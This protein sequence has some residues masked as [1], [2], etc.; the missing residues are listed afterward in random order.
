M[1][2]KDIELILMRQLANYLAVPILVVDPAGTL[3]FYNEPAEVLLGRGIEETGA[4][5]FAEWTRLFPMTAED[6]APLPPEARPLGTALQQQRATHG[7]F[8]IQGFNGIARSVEVTA[9]PLAGQGGR[10]VGAVAIFWQ[11]REP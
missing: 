9:F 4:L 6:G 5:P 7:A 3:L 11:G 10:E 1:P 8:R 2:Q